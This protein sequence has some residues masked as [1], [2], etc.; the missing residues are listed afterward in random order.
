MNENININQEAEK[1]LF[2]KLTPSG[3]N[4]RETGREFYQYN[5]DPSKV[6]RID[7]FD[8]LTERYDNIADPAHI[9]E[10][11]KKLFSEIQADY[12]IKVPVEI[13]IGKDEK[14]KEAVYII[15]DKIEGLSLEESLITQNLEFAKKLETLYVSIS[16]YYLDKLNSKEVHLA[17]LNNMSQYIYGRKE[18]DIED[19]IY[20]VDTDLYLNKGDAYLLHNV[21]WLIRHMPKRFDEAI[22]NIRQIIDSPLSKDLS[23]KDKIM[24]EKEIKES[25]NL[26]DGTF[27]VVESKDEEGFMVSPLY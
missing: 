10:L 17:D 4:K 27:Q 23:D 22:K 16:K 11:G 20:L 1:T 19:A 26:L 14:N 13:I 12:N 7:S 18:G 8:D 21:K 6:I 3:L 15:T 2:S 24:A 5:D 9:V 25:L